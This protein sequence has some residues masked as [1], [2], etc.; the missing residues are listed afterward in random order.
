MKEDVIVLSLVTARDRER[1]TQSL[2]AKY[3]SKYILICPLNVF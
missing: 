3:V 2:L 1:D